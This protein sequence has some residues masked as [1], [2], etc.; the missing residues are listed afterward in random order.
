MC[1]FHSTFNISFR[2]HSSATD[3]FQRKGWPYFQRKRADRETFFAS[4][5]S[6]AVIQSYEYTQ[7]IQLFFESLSATEEQSFEWIKGYSPIL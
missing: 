3:P 5:G 1:E 7:M 4:R 6:F 2:I